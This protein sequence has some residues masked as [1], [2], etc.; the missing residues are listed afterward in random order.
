[1]FLLALLA[2]AAIHLPAR[3]TTSLVLRPPERVV[4][5]AGA[6]RM[7][8]PP[9]QVRGAYAICT[10]EYRAA[11]AALVEASLRCTSRFEG[12]APQRTLSLRAYAIDRTEVTVGAY[13]ACVARGACDGTPLVE[14]RRTSAAGDAFPMEAVTWDEAAAYCRF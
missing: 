3:G 12:E 5:P 8:S 6:F 14:A 4:I 2:A 1:M 7:G 9:E 13:R 11:G 10:E